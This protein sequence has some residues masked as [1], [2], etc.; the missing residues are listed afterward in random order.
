VIVP[1]HGF[2]AS[3]PFS[4]P[5]AGGSAKV[6]THVPDRQQHAEALLLQ[7][8]QALDAAELGMRGRAGLGTE[9]G[10]YL[11]VESRPDVLL[12]TDKLER[13]RKHKTRLLSVRKEGDITKATLFVPEESK[14]LFDKLIHTYENKL[15]PLAHEPVPKGWKLVEGI[16]SF[17][18]A[19]LRDLWTGSPDDFPSEGTVFPWEVWLSRGT[20]E[21]FRA[22]ANQNAIQVSATLLSG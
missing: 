21:R 10:Y 2:S 14:D 1:D 8:A 5:G 20:E 6:P 17:R 3:T 7:Y 4:P 22:F 13:G 18:N 15:E 12:L 19:T 9:N 11:E 16:G